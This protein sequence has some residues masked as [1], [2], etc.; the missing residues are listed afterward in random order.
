MFGY[1]VFDC[2]LRTARFAFWLRPSFFSPR[3]L[4]LS[5]LLIDFFSFFYLFFFLRT[6]SGAGAARWLRPASCFLMFHCEELPL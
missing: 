1:W 4:F 3:A 6:A 2:A 5:N